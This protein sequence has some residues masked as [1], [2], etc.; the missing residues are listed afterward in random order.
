MERV[1]VFIDGSNLYFSLKRNNRSTRV[2]YHELSKA[3]A[4]SDRELVRTFYYNSAYDSVT[5]PEQSKAQQP[6]LESLYKTAYLEARLGKV[7]NFKDVGF[8][9]KGT[10]VL[11]AVDL[12][13][14]AAR[15]I[16]D[17]AIVYTD[18]KDFSYVFNEVK[19]LGKQ[20]EICFFADSQQKE[21]IRG[22]DSFIFLDKVLDTYASK[23]FPN[24]EEEP[25]EN[26][27]TDEPVKK[28]RGRPKKIGLVEGLKKI[29]NG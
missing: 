3:L 2:D 1:C 22:S 21:L 25:T 5:A 12:V 11:L 15:N 13:Y 17:T 16:F 10:D 7:R 18:D 19:E 20:I 24:P 14:Y 6:F 9:E 23:I 4:G 28:K 26:K 27:P 8:T 29:V